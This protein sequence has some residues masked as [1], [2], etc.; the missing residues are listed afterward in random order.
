MEYFNE[1]LQLPTFP[2]PLCFN[3]DTGGFE[4]VSAE[5]KEIAKRIKAA[6]RS[7]IK[8]SRIF[9]PVRHHSFKPLPKLLME[10]PK[11]DGRIEIDTT[12]CVKVYSS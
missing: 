9:Y 7:G 5:K 11:D 12:F 10:E 3:R 1:F 4:I 8:K 2:E 6:I